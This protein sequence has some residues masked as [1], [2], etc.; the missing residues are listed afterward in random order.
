MTSAIT[1]RVL[2]QHANVKDE[3]LR[4]VITSLLSHLHAFATEV[5]L[6]QD[7]WAAGIAFL[8]AAGHITD[9]TR[10]EFILL[11]D[12]L[13]LSMLVDEL[14]HRADHGETESTV[15]GP[16][17]VADAPWRADGEVIARTE[18]G[19]P[20]HVAVRVLSSS[21][22]PV[23]GAVLDT[24]QAARSGLYDVQDPSQPPGNLRGRFHTDASGAVSF[25]TVRPA[26][27][28]IPDDGPVGRMLA[29]LGRHPWR[30]AHVHFR[31]SAEGHQPVT[32]HLFDAT[33][34]YLDSDTVFGVKPSL[35]L[36]FATVTGP[37]PDALGGGSS[38]A[39]LTH[40]FVLAKAEDTR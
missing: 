17:W 36:D 15:L 5:N 27:Y 3:R 38:H 34:A 30:P 21:G 4:Q 11:S 37:V 8:T 12:T 6:T 7:E 9:D 24:W 20:L 22:E 18:D 29:A 33:S 16:F 14:D 39:E 13:G 2:E 23:E 31:V 1:R 26:P 25:W 40:D 19:D 32:T 10:Q 28:P 35:V